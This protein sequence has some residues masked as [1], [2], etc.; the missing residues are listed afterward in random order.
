M[1]FGNDTTYQWM[2][3]MIF[4]FFCSVLI[5]QPLYVWKNYH[6]SWIL[7]LI[8]IKCL[9]Q[10]I[11]ITLIISVCCRR[12]SSFNDDHCDADEEEPTI[13]WDPTKQPRT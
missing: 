11:A 6:P 8:L 10:I 2:V 13:Y 9:L 12:R 1:Q 3:S 7:L 4:A 5:T